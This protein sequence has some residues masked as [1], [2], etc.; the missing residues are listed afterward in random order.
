M[1]SSNHNR[2]RDG[3]LGSWKEIMLEEQN[4]LNAD[5]FL[6]HYPYSGSS[7]CPLYNPESDVRL[8]ADLSEGRNM[9]L[10]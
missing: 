6:L 4:Y 1:G 2:R 10:E 3:A 7:F 5:L 8:H 9:I